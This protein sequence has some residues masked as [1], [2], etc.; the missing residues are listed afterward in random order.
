MP[1][2]GEVLLSTG[3]SKAWMAACA[4][5]CMAILAYGAFGDRES[6]GNL[7]YQVGYNLPIAIFIA[8]GLH[9]AFRKRESSRTS[10]IGFALVYISLITASLIAG[11]RLKSEVKDAAVQVQQSLAAVQAAASAGT[12]TPPPMPVTNV[13]TSDGGKMGLVM[14]T[15]VNRMLAHRREYELELDAIG[16]GKILDG[17]RLKNDVTLAESRTMIQQ[18]KDVVLKYKSKTSDLFAIIRQDIERSDL[19]PSS[20]Q[21]MLAGFDRTSAQGKAQA[22]EVWMLEEQ[23]LEEIGKVFSLL[24]ARRSAWQIQDGQVMFQSQKDLDLFNSY[25]ATVQSLVAKQEQI[26]SSSLKRTTEALNQL[27]K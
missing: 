3:P 25:L 21:S 8:G 10:W 17:Q 26:Q 7:A 19:S 5:V 14:K 9:L 27:T 23:A 18:A 20:K 13:G 24:S 1:A 6:S 2:P 11:Q 15:M 4:A 12:N 16:W 22:M